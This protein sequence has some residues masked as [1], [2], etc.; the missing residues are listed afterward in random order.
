MCSLKLYSYYNVTK[1]RKNHRLC[2]SIKP[3]EVHR[4]MKHNRVL[5][6]KKNVIHCTKH[7]PLG[8]QLSHNL[9]DTSTL[10]LF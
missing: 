5:N 6:W 9:S 3:N 10:D 7:C 8:T 1:K 2:S 4:L